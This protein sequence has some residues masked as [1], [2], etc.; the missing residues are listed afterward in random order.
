MKT[1]ISELVSQKKMS[2]AKLS[3]I[4][5]ISFNAA[6]ELSYSNKIDTINYCYSETR[7]TKCNEISLI[8]AKKSDLDRIKQFYK[9][10]GG[11]DDQ[12]GY[13]ENIIKRN[14]LYM[15][16]IN[17]ENVKNGIIK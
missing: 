15:C 16:E 8:H 5:P 3:S 17:E 6:L 10:E 1:I 7:Q 11:F 9:I 2:G 12:F 14:E 4:E 13:V